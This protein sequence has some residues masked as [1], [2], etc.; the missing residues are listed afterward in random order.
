MKDKVLAELG[1][2]YKGKSLSKTFL[3]QIATIIAGGIT[4]ET[5][6]EGKITELD[7]LITATANE[8]NRRAIEAAQKAKAA[9]APVVE[10]EDEDKTPAEKPKVKPA[11]PDANTALLQQLLEKVTKLESEKSQTSI[12]DK[13]AAAIGKDV[14]ET[15]YKRIAL[16]ATEEEVDE[17]AAEVKADWTALKQDKNNLGLGGDAPRSAGGPAGAAAPSDA[18]IAEI[19]DGL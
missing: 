19:A 15:F 2:K 18:E 11:N 8:G 6:I 10:D 17:L 12:K 5:E 9:A 14:P 13:F 1:L 7:A 4:E 3:D 16:P